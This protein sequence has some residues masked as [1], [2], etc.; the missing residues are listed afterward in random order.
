MYHRGKIG[1]KQG[2]VDAGAHL[3][4]LILPAVPI[5]CSLD[6]AQFFIN[7]LCSFVFQ[8]GVQ[9]DFGKSIIFEQ[10]FAEQGKDLRPQT[11][12]LEG[13]LTYFDSDLCRMIS[14][15]LI[16]HFTDRCLMKFYD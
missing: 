7:V 15:V 14:H 10:T 11:M 13:E 2:I 16:A 9:Y 3:S 6:K 5:D 1:R 4:R 12:I 8:H